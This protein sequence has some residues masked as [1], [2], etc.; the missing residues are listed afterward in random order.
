MDKDEE[1]WQKKYWWIAKQ[2]EDYREKQLALQ[3]AS[4]NK[5]NMIENNK[6]KMLMIENG[7]QEQNALMFMPT[8]KVTFFMSN[9]K[10][11]FSHRVNK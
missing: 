3:A 2:A 6:E 10:I 7:F 1:T 4:E 9:R 5:N 8:T 11:S